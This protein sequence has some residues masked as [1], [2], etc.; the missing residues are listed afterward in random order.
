MRFVAIC[1][2]A[3]VGCF[4]RD[5]MGPAALVQQAQSGPV[6]GRSASVTLA[7]TAAGDAVLVVVALAPARDVSASDV[8]ISSAAGTAS[9]VQV[10]ASC[11]SIYVATI[12]N[13]APG[14]TAIGVTLTGDA[15]FSVAALEFAGTNGSPY[16]T[17][18]QQ[19]GD[20]A[21]DVIAPAL[22]TIRG[23]LVISALATCG[24]ITGLG[25]GSPFTTVTMSDSSALAYFTP[26]REGTY[27]AAWTYSGG[28]WTA[29]SATFE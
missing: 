16:E 2:F 19:T 6:T 8:T 3:C 4:G 21:P 23:Q 28:A 29:W 15:T 13:A 9:P 20:S 1:M 25:T 10:A 7:P 22:H 12:G 27:G 24:T 14:S 26:T 17:G 11:S 18:G 5:A